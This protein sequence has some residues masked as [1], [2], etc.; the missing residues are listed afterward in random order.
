VIDTVNRSGAPFEYVAG[1]LDADHTLA[2]LARFAR[3]VTA[4]SAPPRWFTVDA[5]GWTPPHSDM[6]WVA[7]LPAGTTGETVLACVSAS[8]PRAWLAATLPVF[9]HS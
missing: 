8:P 3:R 4:T 6:T 7:D 5:T 2:D 9:A 1:R